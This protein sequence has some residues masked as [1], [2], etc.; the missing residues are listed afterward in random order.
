MADRR[1]LL[2]RIVRILAAE[3][4]DGLLATMDLIEELLILEQPYQWMS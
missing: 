1:D 3:A 4:A 2:A